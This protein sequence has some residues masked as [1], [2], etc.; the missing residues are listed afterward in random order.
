LNR[1]KP[2]AALAVIKSLYN[3]DQLIDAPKRKLDEQLDETK[4]RI[5]VGNCFRSDFVHW[6]ESGFV[7]PESGFATSPQCCRPSG[8]TD[9]DTGSN[10]SNGSQSNPLPASHFV[11]SHPDANSAPDATS[12][13]A[14][15]SLR[16]HR[17]SARRT[18]A[19]SHP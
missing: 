16:S 10:D 7:S 17:A 9:A 8:Y 11:D 13:A 6:I 19:G 14:T 12:H 18:A 15:D 2:L 3:Q 5:G 1:A 4:I